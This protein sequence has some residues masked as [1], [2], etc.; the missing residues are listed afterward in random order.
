MNRQKTC[1]RISESLGIL[2]N[3]DRS[4]PECELKQTTTYNLTCTIIITNNRFLTVPINDQLVFKTGL[5]TCKNVLVFSRVFINFQEIR[6]LSLNNN[7]VTAIKATLANFCPL[8]IFKLSFVLKCFQ[9][10][11]IRFSF[12]NYRSNNVSFA[13]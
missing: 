1:E 12:C 10:F 2:A 7:K 4:Q 6:K 11:H 3:S 8:Q 13:Q 5:A 9:G